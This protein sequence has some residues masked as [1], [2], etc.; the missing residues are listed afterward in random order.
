MAVW[1]DDSLWCSSV[2]MRM[3]SLCLEVKQMALVVI[4]FTN[5]LD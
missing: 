1:S 4:W 5:G 3:L 2:E